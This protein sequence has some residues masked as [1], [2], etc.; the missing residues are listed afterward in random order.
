MDV[1]PT[2]EKWNQP[3]F[4]TAHGYSMNARPLTV[5]PAPSAR[6]LSRPRWTTPWRLSPHGTPLE[7]PESLLQRR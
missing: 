1:E 7:A 2:Y 4:D 5:D 3:I 6:S